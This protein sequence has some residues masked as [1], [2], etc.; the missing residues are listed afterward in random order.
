MLLPSAIDGN[1]VCSAEHRQDCRMMVASPNPCFR[2]LVSLGVI[3]LFSACQTTYES[4]PAPVGGRTL[5]GQVQYSGTTR[6]FVGEF[7]AISS[8]AA[9]QLVISKGLP[10]ISVQQASDTARIEFAGRSW[11]GSIQRAP[12]QTKTWLALPE[13]FAQVS[14]NDRT[15]FQSK[16]PGLWNADL[17]P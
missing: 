10:L 9:F 5:S 6:S 7:T 17:E 14:A 8:P 2:R 4:I 16:T 12:A 15:H 1:D 11:Q 13:V 3:C